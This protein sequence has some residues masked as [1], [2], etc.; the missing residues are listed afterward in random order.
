MTCSSRSTS[1][2]GPE[3]ISLPKSSTAVT[4]QQADTR[5][6]SWST[7]ITQRA[8]VRRGSAG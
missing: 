8:D 3:A 1:A 7:R 2:V 4:S 6:M 5:L